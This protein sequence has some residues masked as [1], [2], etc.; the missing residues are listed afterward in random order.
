MA[1]IVA[2]AVLGIAPAWAEQ[3]EPKPV[4]GTSQ[5]PP[6]LV[7]RVEE[8]FPLTPPKRLGM[9]T[10]V[11]PQHDGEILRITIPVGELVSRTVRTISDANQRRAE[12][13]ADERVRQ[14]LARFLA[15]VPKSAP[16]P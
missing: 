12:R 15:T 1:I 13:K 14:D 16:A 3:Q 4:G 2:V 11:P 7:V 10:I 9:I 5:P 8:L 6:K